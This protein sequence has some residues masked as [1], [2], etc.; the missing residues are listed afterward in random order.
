MTIYLI[1][2]FAAF[3]VE[4][5]SE[6]LNVKIINATI[7]NEENNLVNVEGFGY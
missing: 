1:C 3:L 6:L 5:F 7:G 4:N 2:I